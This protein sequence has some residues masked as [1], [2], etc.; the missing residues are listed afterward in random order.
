MSPLT[1]A[2]VRVE[3][4]GEAPWRRALEKCVS[5]RAAHGG[6]PSE[7][8]NNKR[9]DGT[10]ASQQETQTEK[11]LKRQKVIGAILRGKYSTSGAEH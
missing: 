9:G 2:N 5:C 6:N 3:G 10:C 8:N 4:A 11:H 1:K 7:T